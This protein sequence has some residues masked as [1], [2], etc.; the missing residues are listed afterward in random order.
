MTSTWPRRVSKYPGRP[1]S[2]AEPTPLHQ[3]SL[4]PLATGSPPPS[5]WM[6]WA[7]TPPHHRQNQHQNLRQNGPP[8]PLTTNNHPLPE[9]PLHLASPTRPPPK[10]PPISCIVST[11]SQ[12][13][14]TAAKL[15]KELTGPLYI[16]TIRDRTSFYT[17]NPRDHDYL[18]KKLAAAGYQPFTSLRHDERQDRV[19]IK[20]LPLSTTPD[21][22]LQQL[23]DGYP[24]SSM[25]PLRMPPDADTKP[26]LVAT[27][28]QGEANQLLAIKNFGGWV[29]KVERYRGSGRVRQCYRCQ[30]LGHNSTRCDRAL[31]CFKCVGEHRSR[32]CTATP[33]PTPPPPPRRGNA[34]SAT[35]PASPPPLTAPTLSPSNAATP[36]AHPNTTPT[37]TTAPPPD[38]TS[39]CTF[40]AMKGNVWARSLYTTQPSAPPNT[41]SNAPLNPTPRSPPTTVPD[42]TSLGDTVRDILNLF[43]TYLPIIRRT[44]TALSCAR[45]PADKIEVIIQAVLSLFDDNTL[46]LNSSSGTPPSSPSSL[47]SSF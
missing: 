30:L 37:A 19:V 10:C 40:P 26:F 3:T 11:T 29:V 6:T 8:Y 45:T 5:A 38:A 9:P 27:N 24:V 35:A 14:L 32:D 28:Y 1:S 12:P 20:R 36:H 42:T 7:T 34:A 15:Q 31:R 21:E 23:H 41:T 47:T 4:S 22:L 17:T 43:H 18:Y 46:P 2:T 25:F 39:Q 13:F 33:P 44:M 16:S